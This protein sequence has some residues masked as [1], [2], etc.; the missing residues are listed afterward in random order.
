MLLCIYLPNEIQRR[1]KKK[2]NKGE[3]KIWVL[4]CPPALLMTKY[5]SPADP[6]AAISGENQTNPGPQILSFSR[7]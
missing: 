6:Q 5:S 2:Q 7:L 3:R 1:K 4:Y